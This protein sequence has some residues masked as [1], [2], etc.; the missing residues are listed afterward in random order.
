VARQVA[1]GAPTEL[2]VEKMRVNAIKALSM[3][4]VR[5][6]LVLGA[7]FALGACAGRQPDR[8]PGPDDGADLPPGMRMRNIDRKVRPGITV[9][10]DDSIKL[11]AGKRVALVTNQTG[12]DEKGRRSVDLLFSDNRSQRAGVKLVKLFAPE[13][14][15]L[16][17]LDREG[18]GD[19][20]DPRTGLTV[21]SLYQRG[22]TAPPDSL[23]QDVDVLVVD[24]QDIGTRTWTYVGVVL[25]TMQAGERRGIPVVVLDRP[26][27][28]SGAVTEG[29]LLDSSL[30]NAEYPTGTNR[31]NGFAIFPSPLRH[32]L[33]MGELARLFHANLKMGTRLTVVPMRNWR[34]G[35]WFD[36][37]DLPWVRPSPNMPNITSALFYPALVPFESSNVSVGRGTNEPFQRFGAP[38][39]RA[40]SVVRLLEDLTLPGVKFRVNRF[41]PNKPGDNKYAGRTIPGIRLELTDRERVQPARV[42]AAILWALSRV[43]G[44]SLKLTLPGFDLRMGSA[45]VREAL[46]GGGDPDA[47]MDRLLPQ[48][49]G[50]EKDARRFHL[51]R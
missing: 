15:A 5:G 43:H 7:T 14:G 24:L 9:L 20:K 28:I 51:Y 39:L 3:R 29:A 33:T 44:D 2:S 31:T 41:T 11:V 48:V 50:F 17:T 8:G 42:G 23:L 1:A 22:T 40:D 32:G 47:V 34:R 12:V 30:A 27:P 26:N 46:Q 13:H 38:W 37:T 4:T 6:W 19:E 49:V 35:M 10:L 16:G 21:H 18:L 36:N 45:R 25:Y